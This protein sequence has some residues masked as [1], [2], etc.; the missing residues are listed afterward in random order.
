MVKQ[1]FL[2]GLVVCA[3][4]SLNVP[5]LDY[6][7]T[8]VTGPTGPMTATIG[9][10]LEFTLARVVQLD[11]DAGQTNP[12]TEGVIETTPSF[13][14]GTLRS[15]TDN[16]GN[17]L[18]MRGHFFYYVLMIAASSGRRYK[19]SETGTQ[20]TSGGGAT[21][22][23]ESV[24]LVPDYQWLDQ[25]GGT[26]QGAPPTGASVGPATSACFTDSLVYQS[27]NGGLPKLVR[28][29]VSI[30]GPQAGNSFPQNFSL[31]FNGSV[32]QGAVQQFTTWTPVTPGQAS[33]TYSGTATFTLVLD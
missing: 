5:V 1:K 17:F 23:K 6:A 2:I 16:L 28:A 30:G 19:I 14:F 4:V 3:F 13:D 32:G 20:L 18:F 10:T 15:V 24:L 8:S 7:Q 26:S 11:A 25:L 29:I 12:F 9:S 33:G 21:L 31:G 27:D 22:P